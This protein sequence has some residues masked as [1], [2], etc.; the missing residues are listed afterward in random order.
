MKAASGNTLVYPTTE[1]LI[2]KE[3]ITINIELANVKLKLLPNRSTVFVTCQKTA[4]YFY[5]KR[6]IHSPKNYMTT[7][8]RTC[9][10]CFLGF[11]A[12]ADWLVPTILTFLSF[13][14][15]SFFSLS[16]CFYWLP[17]DLTRVSINFIQSTPL[18][19]HCLSVTSDRLTKK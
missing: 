4:A 10:T 18:Q 3:R 14:F 6:F 5:V 12:S 13:F 11:S 8:H 7:R 17:F 19:A 15:L 1:D 2:L 16:F 9:T